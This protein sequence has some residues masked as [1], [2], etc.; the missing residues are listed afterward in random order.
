MCTWPSPPETVIS[1]EMYIYKLGYKFLCYQEVEVIGET[2]DRR[3]VR[4]LQ[5]TLVRDTERLVRLREQLTSSIIAK[6]YADCRSVH[7]FWRDKL[8]TMSCSSFF[9]P[10]DFHPWKH[11]KH[12]LSTLYFVYWIQISFYVWKS[13][14]AKSSKTVDVLAIPSSN[15][16]GLTQV[17][18]PDV[19][20]K[21]RQFS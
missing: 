21:S 13:V 7:W 1:S 9:Q 11:G 4:S 16:S 19:L 8:L 10:I 5:L 12:A 20:L 14:G 15:P 17:H 3:K 18:S 2:N 6:N